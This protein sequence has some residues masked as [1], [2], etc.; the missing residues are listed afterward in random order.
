VT[1]VPARIKSSS[2]P[3][4][5][6]PKIGFLRRK[7]FSRK[8]LFPAITFY[9]YFSVFSPFSQRKVFSFLLH[10]ENDTSYL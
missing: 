3:G 6:N 2:N 10:L 5:E 8:S 9:F 7:F 4:G 1:D